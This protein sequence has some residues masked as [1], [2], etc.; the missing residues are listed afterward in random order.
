MF[1]L[2]RPDTPLRPL[3][4]D[5]G[6]RYFIVKLLARAFESKTL[7]CTENPIVTRLS[8]ASRTHYYGPTLPLLHTLQGCCPSALGTIAVAGLSIVVFTKFVNL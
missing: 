4:A 1:D 2:A 6:V 8:Q 5:R 7:W 3:E